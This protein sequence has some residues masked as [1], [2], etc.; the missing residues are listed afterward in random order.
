MHRSGPHDIGWVGTSKED[1]ISFPADVRREFGFN[2][3]LM[4]HHEDPRCEFRSLRD[5]KP[6]LWE[7]K[8]QDQDGWY[9]LVYLAAIDGVIW[10][11]HCFQK[12]SREMSKPDRELIIKRYKAL[13]DELAEEKRR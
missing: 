4:Q 7:L 11:L 9:R 2:L 8:E 13:R 10:V 12:K 3:Y 5:I 6:G 1:L